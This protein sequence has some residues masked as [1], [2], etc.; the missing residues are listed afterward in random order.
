MKNTVMT[1]VASTAVIAGMVVLAVGNVPQPPVAHANV[2]DTVKDGVKGIINKIKEFKD[3]AG[4]W[5]QSAINLAVEKGY[6]DGFQDGS[7]HPDETLTRAQFLK[8]VVV[9]TNTPVGSASG[10]AWHTPFVTAAT[11]AGIISGSDFSDQNWDAPMT[12]LEMAKVAVRAAGIQNSDNK[13]W[14]YLATK[15]GLVQ[16]T[17]DTGSLSMEKTTTRAESVTIIERVLSVKNGKQLPVDKHAVS[18]AEIEWHGTNVFTM[19]PRYFPEKFADNF[20]I[21]KGQWDSLDGR[22]HEKLL[23]YIVVDME[24]PNDPF[25]SEVA[26][27]KFTFKGVDASGKPTKTK[28]YAAPNKSYVAFSKVSQK[29]TDS[30]PAGWYASEGGSVRVLGGGFGPTQDRNSWLKEYSSKEN[31]STVLF[32]KEQVA[33]NV[34]DNSVAKGNPY[35]EHQFEIGKEY[36]WYQ[37]NLFP[38][39][40]MFTAARIDI[41]FNPNIEYWQKSGAGGNMSEFSLVNSNPD[42]SVSNP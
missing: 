37:A 27:M 20:D 16:G 39:G 28:T 40:N 24:D 14:M 22:Y 18:R 23:A 15:A 19:W 7:F 21:S 13:K 9:A 34:I 6:V 5:A 8:M 30:Y 4:H 41:S 12:R 29:L 3:T 26:G 32:T 10:E 33:Q 1:K 35:D 11:N 31:E 36:Y 2:A 42:F 25:R 38:K 17:D